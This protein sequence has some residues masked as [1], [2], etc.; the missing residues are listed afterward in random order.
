MIV[1]LYTYI[2][3]ENST[4]L[5]SGSGQSFDCVL[6]NNTSLISPVLIID[7]E[8]QANPQPHTYNYAYIPD[9]KRWY[10][11][12]DVDVL[13]GNVWAISMTVDV[14]GSYRDT[15]RASYL[16]L[17]RNAILYDGDIVDNYYPIKTTYTE[18]E[19]TNLTPWVPSIDQNIQIEL[20]SFIIGFESRPGS[21]TDSVYGSVKYVAL[22]LA[23]LCRLVNY[24][25]DSNNISGWSI[26]IDGVSNEA[27]KAIINPLSFI[28]SCQWSPIMYSNIDT[29]E[30]T[31]LNIWSWSVPS[32]SYKIMPN[33]PPYVRWS[34]SLDTIP[35]HPQASRGRYL[36]TEP[37]T[38]MTMCFP[39]FGLINLDT[40]LTATANT[41]RNDITYDVITGMAILETY[42]EGCQIC[43]L[44]SQV[45]VPI[46]L[47]QVYNDYL[48][49]AG[50]VTGGIMNTLGNLLSGNIAGTITSAIGA[51]GSAANAM[52]PINSS[53]GGSGGF[54]D[55]AGF[56]RLHATFYDIAEEDRG[57][58]GRPLCREVQMSQ[59]T[60]FCIA[61]HGD[62]AIN[63]TISEQLRLKQFLESGFFNE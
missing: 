20:G 9:F 11:I 10:F 27:A 41:I 6:K 29:D 47:S 51:V 25:M 58:A 63:G 35:R 50:G 22:D 8:D 17:L 33:D 37:F 53:L 30:K 13:R 60:G 46:Q 57:H 36:N 2:K 40:T 26:N 61:M 52:R 31:G 7:F 15:I 5:P 54:A 12:Q 39:P 56:V 42:I 32:V 45:G 16:Y 14:L 24:L 48:G 59:A 18:R 3:R 55:L 28:K 4:A 43:R 38:N 62:L 19:V 44:Q 49:S 1:R 34:V 23:N 21:D